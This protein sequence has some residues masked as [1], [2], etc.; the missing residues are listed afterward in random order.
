MLKSHLLSYQLIVFTYILSSK[1]PFLSKK[2][3]T[4]PKGDR[5][6]TRFLAV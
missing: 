2:N 1:K 4:Y 6:T 3:I 5:I